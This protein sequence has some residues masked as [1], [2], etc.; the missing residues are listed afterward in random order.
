MRI[1]EIALKSKRRVAYG[2]Y[3]SEN[4]LAMLDSLRSKFGGAEGYIK[5]KCGLNDEDI[6][7]I[8]SN[9]VEKNS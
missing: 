1:V 6:R 4:I 7:K 2:N 3:R 5:Q 9:L 8:R